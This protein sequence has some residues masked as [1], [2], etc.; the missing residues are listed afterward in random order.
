VGIKR[1]LLVIRGAAMQTTD[2]QVKIKWPVTS[3]LY[4]LRTQGEEG[5]TRRAKVEGEEIIFKG[6]QAGVI[7]TKYPK[8]RV[9]E[10]DLTAYPDISM[11]ILP[12]TPAAL[13]HNAATNT[14]CA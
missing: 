10:G 6:L 4:S 3:L 5:N 12:S 9:M 13:R 11:K 14:V 7:K 2:K 1:R 8:T